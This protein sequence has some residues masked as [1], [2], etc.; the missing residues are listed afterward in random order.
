MPENLSTDVLTRTTRI[1]AIVAGV[2]TAIACIF[3]GGLFF[4]LPVCLIL[5]ALT[6]PRAPKL[7]KWLLWIAAFLLSILMIPIGA[8]VVQETT[9]HF[10]TNFKLAE[11][12]F[13][14][15]CVIGAVLVLC[16][17]VALLFDIASAK[18]TA[19]TSQPQTAPTHHLEWL[20][21]IA[22]IALSALALP[23]SILAVSSFRQYGRWDISAAALAS[24]IAVIL[25][26]IAVIAN[27]IKTHRTSTTNTPQM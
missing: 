13:A 20:V 24:G 27:A 22:A 10:S 4:V 3:L 19:K 5:G 26:D 23:P 15:V 17:D 1:L 2:F 18:A 12:A 25:F 7:G 14:A 6:Q 11:T 8:V 21:W 16:C 9:V